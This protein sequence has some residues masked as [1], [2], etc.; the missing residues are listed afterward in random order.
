MALVDQEVTLGE[1]AEAGPRRWASLTDRT[2]RFSRPA[3]GQPGG[4]ILEGNQKT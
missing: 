1:V 4:L 2:D 3:G